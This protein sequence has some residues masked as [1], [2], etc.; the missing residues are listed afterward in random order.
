MKSSI[1]GDRDYE[2]N[3]FN[4]IYPIQ[5][6]HYEIFFHKSCCITPPELDVKRVTSDFYIEKDFIVKHNL[7]RLIKDDE[8]WRIILER[9]NPP[10]DAKYIIKW[11][12]PRLNELQT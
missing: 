5:Q 9:D 11:R 8:G 6:F 3:S 12:P 2:Y 4:V 1:T 10:I 7:F